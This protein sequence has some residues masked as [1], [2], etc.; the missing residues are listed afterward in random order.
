[1]NRRQTSSLRAMSCATFRGSRAAGLGKRKIAG[2]LGISATATPRRR[3]Q[4]GDASPNALF[5]LSKLA[6]WW[7]RLGVDIERIKPGRPQRNRRHERMHLT[8]KKETVRPP[9]NSLQ[10]Q[11]RFDDFVREYNTERPPEALEMKCPAVTSTLPVGSPV[12]ACRTSP[13]PSTTATSSSPLPPNLH[14]SQGRTVPHHRNKP[15]AR[16][17]SPR[18][19]KLMPGATNRS[20]RCRPTRSQ[21]RVF[22]GWQC[23]EPAEFWRSTHCHRG[24]GTLD[25]ELYTSAMPPMR[26]PPTPGRPPG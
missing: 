26:G 15:R 24:G 17:S 16:S 1:M 6:V 5:N 25:S 18:R 2:S 14:L 21:R 4:K 3:L 13:T 12:A 23:V 8:L 19:W 22:R 10:Q 7:L 9:A 20:S 11:A